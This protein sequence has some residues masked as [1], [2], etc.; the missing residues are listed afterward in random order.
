MKVQSDIQ[1]NVVGLN[2][3]K[4]RLNFFLKLIIKLESIG[5]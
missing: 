2:F 5:S 1:E 3:L 4:W